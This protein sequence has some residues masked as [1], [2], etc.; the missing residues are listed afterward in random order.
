MGEGGSKSEKNLSNY[1]EAELLRRL[2]VFYEYTY[3]KTHSLQVLNIFS[4]NIPFTEQSKLLQ[5]E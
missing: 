2:Y 4:M 3:K 1:R 5:R